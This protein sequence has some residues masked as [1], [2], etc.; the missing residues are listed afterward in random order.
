MVLRVIRV[1]LI[2][3]GVSA[4][5]IGY[6]GAEQS[7]L[8][9]WPQFRGLTAGAVAD[10]P[11]LPDQWST[12][13]NVVWT[14]DLPGLGWSSPVVAGDYLY[15]TSRDGVTLVLETGDQ[16]RVVA[17]NTLDDQVD[18]SAAVVGSEIYLR[19]QQYLYC[20]ADS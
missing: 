4:W 10:E 14:V 18:A 2:V 9:E 16:L 13:E 6:A 3:A 7:L 5:L 1:M 15:V 17:T 19:G 12:T 11:S 20:I 8:A